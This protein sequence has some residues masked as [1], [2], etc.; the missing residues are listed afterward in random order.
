MFRFG[1]SLEYTHHLGGGGVESG[2]I[3]R[4]KIGVKGGEGLTDSSSRY[5]KSHS[6][7]IESEPLWHMGFGK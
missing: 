7:S 3:G 1:Y 2:E 6:G 5:K 4:E